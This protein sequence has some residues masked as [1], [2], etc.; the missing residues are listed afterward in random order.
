MSCCRISRTIGE[1]ARNEGGTGRESGM[2]LERMEGRRS[3]WGF[4]FAM[5]NEE[6]IVLHQVAHVEWKDVRAL[7]FNQRAVCSM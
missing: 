6:A 3:P 2:K 4:P 5:G 1:V 7:L